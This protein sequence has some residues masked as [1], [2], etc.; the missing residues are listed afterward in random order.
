VT[1]VLLKKTRPIILRIWAAAPSIV[2]GVYAGAVLPRADEA[3]AGAPGGRRE[4]V[5][6]PHDETLRN[7][8]AQHYPRKFGV[9]LGL[10]S[11]AERGG[12]AYFLRGDGGRA[13]C[14]LRWRVQQKELFSISDDAELSLMQTMVHPSEKSGGSLCSQWPHVPTMP[15]Q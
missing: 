8:H 11:V 7:S 1:S 13:P 12:R 3:K 2:Y 6:R 5:A 15:Q 14:E 10:D 4:G 9:V